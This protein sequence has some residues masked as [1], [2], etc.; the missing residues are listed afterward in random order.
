M[1]NSFKNSHLSIFIRTGSSG[2][3]CILTPSTMEYKKT[4]TEG[5][6]EAEGKASIKSITSEVL[7]SVFLYFLDE[8]TRIYS[9]NNPSIA[10]YNLKRMK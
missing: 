8:T 2:F 1:N 3:K 9:P 6:K 7:G 10:A 5:S 4:V